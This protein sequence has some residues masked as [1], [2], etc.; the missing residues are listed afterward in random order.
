MYF[1]TGLFTASELFLTVDIIGTE[2]LYNEETVSLFL[3]D[4]C[5]K[6]TYILLKLIT[7]YT[8]LLHDYTEIISYP[9]SPKIFKL[10]SYCIGVVK[11][12]PWLRKSNKIGGKSKEKKLCRNAND[13]ETF[14]KRQ[15]KMKNFLR[16]ECKNRF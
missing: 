15:T 11:A 6:R 1:V 5:C 9:V 7:H 16:E 12:G 8:Y 3:Y 14:K 4:F 2:P 10:A 13:F